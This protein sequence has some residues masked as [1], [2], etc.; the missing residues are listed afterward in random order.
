MFDQPL[1]PNAT[2]LERALAAT[3][4]SVLDLVPL[5]AREVWDMDTCPAELLPWLAWTYGVDAWDDQWTE[6][7]KR[8][9]IKSSVSVHR[10]KGTIGAVKDAIGALGLDAQVQE[11]FNQVPPGDPYTFKLI[12]N[13]QQ[14]GIS[15]L[16]FMRLLETVNSARNLRSWL[17]EVKATISSATT[18]KT[19]A[20][21]C[22]GTE[23]TLTNYVS[24]SP[25]EIDEFSI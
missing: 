10:Y 14:V 25:M 18:L 6:E 11:W 23:I 12:I 2:A 20:A 4:A 24:P 3:M 1:P 17:D 7:Q 5:R 22:V 19:A 8:K 9:V 16:Q 13:A 15:Q 21:S